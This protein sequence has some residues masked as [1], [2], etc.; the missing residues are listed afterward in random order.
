MNRWM[1]TAALLL[2]TLAATA[3]P[4]PDKKVL[5][6]EA[7]REIAAAAAQEAGRR[8]ARVVIAVVDDGGFPLYLQR[9]DGAQVASSQVAIDKARTAAIYRRPS[10]VFEDQVRDG[11]A[12]ALALSG[13]VP[14]QGGLPIQVND[15]VV[16]AIGVSGETPQEDEDIARAGLSALEPRATEDVQYFDR[17]HVVQAFAQGQPLRETADYKVHASR[18]TAPGQ[19]EIHQHETDVLYVVEGSATVVTG[20][21]LRDGREIAAGEIRGQTLEGGTARRLA[22]GDVLVVPRGTPHWFKEIHQAPFLYFVVKPIRGAG[23]V[24]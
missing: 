9:G 13:A 18:R 10:K 20:G 1:P 6:L 24:S 11:R 21:V 17:Q 12:S 7:A 23:G 3:A 4:L 5:T 19:V 8:K 16:G 2:Y 15:V 22:P 14:L